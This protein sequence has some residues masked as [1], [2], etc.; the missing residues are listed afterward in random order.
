MKYLR[1]SSYIFSLFV[2]LYVRVWIE[3]N[4]AKRQNLTHQVTLYVRVWIE[5][6]QVRDS[7]F[8]GQVTLYVRVWIEIFA[9]ALMTR[10]VTSPST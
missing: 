3:I 9:P 7:L 10:G 6:I 1:I 4:T 2:T 5:I 8:D